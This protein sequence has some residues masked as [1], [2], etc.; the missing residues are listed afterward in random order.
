MMQNHQT[1]ETKRVPTSFLYW[2]A[3]LI[4]GDG[5]FYISKTNSINRNTGKKY[6]YSY[7]R[8]EIRA[9]IDEKSNIHKI[10]TILGFGTVNLIKNKLACRYRLHNTNCIKN[11]VKLMNGKFRLKKRQIQFDKVCL[12]MGIEPKIRERQLARNAW[13]SGFFE[14][15]GSFVRNRKN[16]GL[17]ISIG[18]TDRSILEKIQS[19][20]NGNIYMSFS[21][22]RG[23]YCYNYTC[24]KKSDIEKWILYFDKFGF[25]GP[26]RVQYIQ[27]KRLLLFKK[28]GY[29]TAKDPKLRIKFF[30]LLR[31]FRN[32][33]KYQR[34]LKL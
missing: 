31:R 30:K 18:Q 5:C 34:K 32:E 15:D 29:H 20:F 22:K 28:R 13:L 27:F 11:F 25:Y 24:S 12:S 2:L 3:G 10:K 7:P 19:E 1:S 8:L 4:D 17:I 6:C 16:L 33:K 21:K 9:H 14:A 23:T 26:K